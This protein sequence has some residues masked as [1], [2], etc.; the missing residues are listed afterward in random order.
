MFASYRQIKEVLLKDF[1]GSIWAESNETV[2]FWFYTWQSFT[3]NRQEMQRNE[4][5]FS[6]VDMNQLFVHDRLLFALC[7]FSPSLPLQF[8]MPSLSPLTL[9]L[10]TKLQIAISEGQ[11]K[12]E[13]L[14]NTVLLANRELMERRGI[15]CFY[16]CSSYSES[17]RPLTSQE[18]H[19]PSSSLARKNTTFGE[20]GHKKL[21]V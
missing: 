21:L 2:S 14:I 12:L 20:Q 17:I 5:S 8:S 6:I 11:V 10:G 3:K 7:L 9:L 1:V 4:H 13:L 18:M 19:L 16:Q 15:L